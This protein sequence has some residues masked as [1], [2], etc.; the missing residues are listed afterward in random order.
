MS[1]LIEETPNIAMTI[2]DLCVYQDQY[3]FHRSYGETIVGGRVSYC[4]FPFKK[5]KDRK[6]YQ[7]QCYT[8]F[9]KA[10]LF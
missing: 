6:Y 2:F 10:F 1:K 8:R 9:I 5:A 3:F 7:V 4:F